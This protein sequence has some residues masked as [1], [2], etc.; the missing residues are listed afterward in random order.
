LALSDI[1]ITA[2]AGT[3]VRCFQLA[4]GDFDQV[5]REARATAMSAAVAWTATTAGTASVISADVT[6]VGLLIVSQATGTVYLR[7]DSTIPNP[8][9]GTAPLYHWYLQ[10]QDRYEVPIQ[11]CT[12]AVSMVASTAGGFVHLV[13]GTAA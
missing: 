8:T 13:S 6:R 5:V 7:F 9:A 1:A 10:P 11:Y 3:N 12:L 2:G 4:G